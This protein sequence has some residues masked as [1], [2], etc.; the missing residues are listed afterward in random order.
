VPKHVLFLTAEELPTTP[1]GKIRKFELVRR[2]AEL[3]D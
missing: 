3:L 2:A 1:T